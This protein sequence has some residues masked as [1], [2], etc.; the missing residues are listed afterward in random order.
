MQR[1]KMIKHSSVTIRLEAI[2][3]TQVKLQF[4][5]FSPIIMMTVTHADRE[6]KNESADY[7]VTQARII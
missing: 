4:T 7:A 2:Q 5:R 6:E 3:F 1:I